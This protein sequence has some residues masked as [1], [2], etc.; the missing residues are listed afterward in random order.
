VNDAPVHDYP[1][2]AFNL[3]V[4]F[5]SLHVVHGTFA[6]APGDLDFAGLGGEIVDDPDTLRA[7]EA[8]L[9]YPGWKPSIG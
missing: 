4:V 2:E 9:G 1:I 7:E 8:P 3:E 5:P 6:T